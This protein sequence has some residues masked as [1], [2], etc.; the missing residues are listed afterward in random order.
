MTRETYC[1]E[2]IKGLEVIPVDN[3]TIILVDDVLHTGRTIRAAMN[4]LFDYGRPAS[5]ILV[6]LIGGQ[7]LTRA[8]ADAA[9][10]LPG[11]IWCLIIGVV[12]RNLDLKRCTMP[13]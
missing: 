12:I 11:F 1:P 6:C 13:R 7:L 8:L 3:K 9:I 2:N 4:E 5:I 10:T